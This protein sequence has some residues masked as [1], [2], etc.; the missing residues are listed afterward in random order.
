MK[1]RFNI[2][3]SLASAFL[4]IQDKIKSLKEGSAIRSILYSTAT[5][6]ENV[7]SEIDTVK[8][9]AYI[10]TATGSYLDSAIE[11]M[12]KVARKDATY[13]SGYVQLEL[14]EP[15]TASNLSSLKL[16]FV[17][18][19]QQGGTVNTSFNNAIKIQKV[20]SGNTLTYYICEPLSFS[21]VDSDFDIDPQ[22]GNQVLLGKY[23]DYLSTVMTKTG[24]PIRSLILPIVADTGGTANNLQSEELESIV[25][26]GI[27]ATVK[28]TFYITQPTNGVVADVDGV[29][30]YPSGTTQTSSQQVLGD[31]SYIT[32]GANKESDDDYRQ[33]FYLYMNSLSRGTLDS[34][35]YAV[36]THIANVKVKAVE[37]NVP[38][39]VVVYVDSPQVIS[40]SLLSKVNDVVKNYRSAGILV[41]IRPTKVDYIT[42]LTDIDSG[43]LSSSTDTVRSGLASYIESK[44]LNETLTYTE[45]HETLDTPDI[46]KSDNVYYG[47]FLS[48][49][50]YNR[51]NG[52]LTGIM[53]FMSD[54]FAT[55][56]LTYEDYMNSVTTGDIKLFEKGTT[57]IKYPLIQLVRTAKTL[58]ATQYTGTHKGDVIT[59]IQT[60]CASTTRAGA[61]M[62][63]MQNSSDPSVTGLAITVSDLESIVGAWYSNYYKIK[64]MTVPPVDSLAYTDAQTFVTAFMTND[65]LNLTYDDL[66]EAKVDEF[67][68]LRLAKN[69]ALNEGLY[70]TN[71]LVGTRPLER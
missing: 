67:N 69:Y 51:Y 41:N 10:D 7:Y 68:K 45:I 70:K 47:H 38:G 28:N 5:E 30:T 56:S 46:R 8:S 55:S 48:P 58:D 66:L 4:A 9:N 12:T 35:E 63:L 25:N 71:Y 43:N 65:V 64:F 21:L 14:A 29:L 24:Q 52:T 15:I 16:S 37:S 3:N 23:K 31:Y 49:E 34:I 42:I 20:K 27:P 36:K 40:K 13:A 26:L 2:Y 50:K 53:S 54:S 1:D 44:N 19:D 57:N 61:C 62:E 39:R 11:G 18:Y 33:R 60:V 6:L 32:G 59:A 17:N 22:T